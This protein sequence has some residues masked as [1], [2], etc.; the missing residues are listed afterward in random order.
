MELTVAT[1]E[2]G[3][4]FSGVWGF[5][6]LFPEYIDEAVFAKL[7]A[8]QNLP[9]AYNPYHIGKIWDIHHP[10]R[11]A[12][13]LGILETLSKAVVGF[14]K[15]GL[16][17]DM[18]EW[19]DTRELKFRLPQLDFPQN[20][21]IADKIDDLFAEVTLEDIRV[22]K[23]PPRSPSPAFYD[24]AA[25]DVAVQASKKRKWEEFEWVPGFE[26]PEPGVPQWMKDHDAADEARKQ[27][28]RDMPGH[29][30]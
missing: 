16:Y 7:P 15:F 24:S 29:N 4:K 13:A 27:L 3:I 26:Q 23:P 22:I 18:K 14:D 30:F 10:R 5:A 1:R 21:R 19:F 8:F 2:Y 25:R 20:S 12:L 28:A 9:R 17:Q 11:R 6:K